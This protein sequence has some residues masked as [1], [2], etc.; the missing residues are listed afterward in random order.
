MLFP[1]S[2]LRLVS[3]DNLFPLLFSALFDNIRLLP[4]ADFHHLKSE[5]G[6]DNPSFTK[7]IKHRLDGQRQQFHDSTNTE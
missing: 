1:R 7:D 6:P 2:K 3:Q 4:P 5:T